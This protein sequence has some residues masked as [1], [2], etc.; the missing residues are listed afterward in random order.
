MCS[1]TDPLIMKAKSSEI[2]E[3]IEKRFL[4]EKK[5]LENKNLTF[6]SNGQKIEKSKTLKDN[7]LLKYSTILIIASEPE[8]NEEK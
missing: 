1:T 5:E 8:K 7:K 2:F 6:L 3:D 4:I